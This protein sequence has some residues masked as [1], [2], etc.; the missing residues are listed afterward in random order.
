MSYKIK[1]NIQGKE[2]ELDT[3]KTYMDFYKEGRKTYL[4]IINLED[5][6]NWIQSGK[7]SVDNNLENFMQYLQRWT[8]DA[9]RKRIL[10]DMK[11]SGI[12]IITTDELFEDNEKGNEIIN[13]LENM[14]LFADYF[15]KTIYGK[16]K[17]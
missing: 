12:T 13:N 7:I 16:D 14:G 9:P 4:N 3:G 15:L 11:K 8:I 17:K 5:M 2:I 1:Y 10:R 6:L